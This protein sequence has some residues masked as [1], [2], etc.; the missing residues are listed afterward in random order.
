MARGTRRPRYYET[1]GKFVE[2]NYPYGDQARFR[3]ALPS[4]EDIFRAGGEDTTNSFNELVRLKANPDE[5]YDLL[6]AIG[7][8]SDEPIQWTRTERR[9]AGQLSNKCEK[10]AVEIE[11]AREKWPFGASM[12][13]SDFMKW[14]ELPELLRSYAKAWKKELAHPFRSARSPRNENIVRLVRYVKDKTGDYRYQQVADLLNATDG[15][16]GWKT[17]DENLRWNA[18]NLRWIK[19][20]AKKKSE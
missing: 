14:E 19:F 1:Q 15:A 16:Y 4:L 2:R 5:L 11:H 7:V 20:R 10:L 9:T 17:R 18:D 6:R 8:S 12:V 3:V 13:Y